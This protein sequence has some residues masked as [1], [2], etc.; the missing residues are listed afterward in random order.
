MNKFLDFYM[1]GTNS[2]LDRDVNHMKEGTWH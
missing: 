1:L 2:S